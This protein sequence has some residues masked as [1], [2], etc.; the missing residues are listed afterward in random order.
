MTFSVLSLFSG[1]GGLDYG[2]RSSGYNLS[3]MVEMDKWAC[4]TLRLN[5]N[6][7]ILQSDIHKITS[8]ELGYAD[9]LIGGPPCQPFSKSAY[10]VLGDTKRLEDPRADT[11]TAFLRVLKDIRPKVFL[12]ENVVGL[13]FKGKDE[14]FKLLENT[15]KKINSDVGT[16]YSFNWKVLN[17][18]DYGVPQS[19]ERVFIVGSKDGRV[20]NFPEP[21]HGDLKSKS[22]DLFEKKILPHITA[23]DA[24]G[25][26][27]IEE[28]R[29]GGQIT[30]KWGDLLPSIPEGKNYLWHTDRGEGLPLFGWRRKY[31]SFLLK[32]AKNRPSWTIQSQPGA[33]IGPFHWRNRKLS[34]KEMCRLQ[35]FP[36]GIKIAGSNVEIQRQLGN[37]VPS[38]L[39]EV[40]ATEIRQQLLDSPL[41]RKEYKLAIKPAIFTPE[42]EKTKKVPSKYLPLVGVHSPHPGT[43]KGNI[44]Q[45]TTNNKL[46]KSM[47]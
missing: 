28:D 35:T 9:V 17:S 43:G 6:C 11:L 39:A 46:Q 38:L 26:I 36:E 3:C 10:W 19:R 18:A 16:N 14:G 22:I 40:L 2:F 12:L 41:N 32:L 42:P 8:D 47:K 30:G 13:K 4:E 33:S 27:E 23:W 37:A 5:E 29:N 7:R 31:W 45:K 34:T 24:I 1:A 15:V 25:D 20:F 21:T 44:A